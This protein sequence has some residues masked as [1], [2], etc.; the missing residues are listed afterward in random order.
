MALDGDDDVFEMDVIHFDDRHAGK[1]FFQGLVAEGSL[2]ALVAYADW[3]PALLAPADIVRQDLDLQIPARRHDLFQDGLELRRERLVP[4]LLHG[5]RQDLLLPFPVED[6]QMPGVLV[7]RNVAHGGKARLQGFDE[8]L[9][10][11]VD[12]RPERP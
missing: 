9:V 7:G 11:R 10:Q 1:I 2:H 5:L 12:F 4:Q 3:G 8:G 6:R